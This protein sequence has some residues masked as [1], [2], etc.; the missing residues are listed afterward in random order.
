MEGHNTYFFVIPVMVL[1]G[2][3]PFS[4]VSIQSMVM[5]WK[6]RSENDL[7]LF[8]MIIV[9][10]VIIFFSFSKTKLPNYTI[11]AYPF[12]AILAGW[13]MDKLISRDS[14]KNH[15][16][17][18]GWIYLAVVSTVPVILNIYMKKDITLNPFSG[19]SLYFLIL[20][21]AAI[22]AIWLIY[23]NQFLN[24]IILLS[25]SWMI[26]IFQFFFILYPKI[27]TQ[28][29]IAKTLPLIDKN[30]TVAAFGLYNSSYSFYLKK[31]FIPLH[32]TIDLKKFVNQNA[33]GYVIS[34]K[35]R[36]NEIQKV[37]GLEII[38]EEKDLFEN[39]TTIILQVR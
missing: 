3:L 7:P 30:K 13:Y 28:N 39:T 24:S 17:F 38:A 8:S 35:Q 10:T 16:I 12:F 37:K 21:L 34:R 32:D 25:V 5:A 15:M 2:M 33:G 23:K 14:K 26:L 6:K 29:P 36:L 20:P 18:S 22:P 19:L 27:D 11:P 9:L 4:M 31:P 1:I